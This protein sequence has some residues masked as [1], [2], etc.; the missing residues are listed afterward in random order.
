VRTPPGWLNLPKALRPPLI[1]WKI[2]PDCAELA[3]RG[4]RMTAEFL[5]NTRL[6]D[7]SI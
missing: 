4:R 1:V 3:E 7:R 2:S 5:F 6:T